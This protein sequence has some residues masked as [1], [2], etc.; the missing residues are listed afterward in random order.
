MYGISENI[1]I[2]F[3]GI[4][5][6]QSVYQILSEICFNKVFDVYFIDAS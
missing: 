2:F 4:E 1:F 5:F 3:D 6:I